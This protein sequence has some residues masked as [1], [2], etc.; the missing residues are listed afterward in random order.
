[1][2]NN[3]GLT[4][5][6]FKSE[7]VAFIAI[8]A[9]AIAVTGLVQIAQ[10]LTGGGYGY[11]T[12]A[13]NGPAPVYR[14]YAKGNLGK[15]FFTISATERNAALS[16]GYNDEGTGFNGYSAQGTSVAGTSPVYRAYNPTTQDHFYTTNFA[17]YASAQNGGYKQ[18][19]VG[20]NDYASISDPASTVFVNPVY[21]V[22]KAS[23]GDHFYTTNV[24]E[25]DAAIAGGYISEGT[26][27]Y[28]P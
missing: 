28:T 17:E 15:H 27:F 21:R 10:G 22:Y 11:G 8:V 18:E 23:T 4:W 12:P 1:M 14:T 19:G 24:A 5:G 9:T 6:Q 26:A 7:K 2:T 16:S 25:R 20:F 3:T 13:A